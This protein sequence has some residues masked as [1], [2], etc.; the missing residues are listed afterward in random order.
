M[1]QI[2]TLA[3]TPGATNGVEWETIAHSK[4]SFILIHHSP[5]FERSRWVHEP[6]KRPFTVSYRSNKSIGWLDISHH[7]T[8]AAAEKAARKAAQVEE[9]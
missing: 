7:A 4:Q 2:H 3:R 6:R 8:L 9:G 1:M 5:T